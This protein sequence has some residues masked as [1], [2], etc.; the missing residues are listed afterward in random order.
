MKFYVINLEKRNDRLEAFQNAFKEFGPYGP[1]GLVEVIKAVDGTLSHTQDFDAIKNFEEFK[2][3]SLENDYNNN[4]R[5]AACSMS[6][7]RAWK[8]IIESGCPGIIYEDDVQFRPTEYFRKEWP[9]ISLDI[10]SVI[11]SDKTSDKTNNN[12]PIVYLGAG[13]ILPIHTNIRTESLLRAQEKSHVSKII[14]KHV[15]VPNFKSSYIFSWLGTF[16]YCIGPETAKNLL[17][18]LESS[19]MKTAVDVF[20]KHHTEQYVLYPF[21]NYHNRIET[22][23][24]DVAPINRLTKAS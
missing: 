22:C 11:T 7:I 21:V 16:A 20:L 15:G 23:D 8:R 6:H 2:Y 9:A 13:D 10:T 19:P 3:I 18:H 5:I 4:P 24:S 12:N 1:E 14:N 17:D